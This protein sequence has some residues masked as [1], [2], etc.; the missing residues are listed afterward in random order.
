VIGSIRE[1]KGEGEIGG[2]LNQRQGTE[3]RGSLGKIRK[4]DE[5]GG[6]LRSEQ[7]HAG[8]DDRRWMFQKV[9]ASQFSR[10]TMQESGDTQRRPAGSRKPNVVPLGGRKTGRSK[11]VGYGKKKTVWG[12]R[13]LDSNAA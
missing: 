11:E 8:S 9:S 4:G 5:R 12:T 10:Q 7:S 1:K 6:S 3:G 13:G 2:R